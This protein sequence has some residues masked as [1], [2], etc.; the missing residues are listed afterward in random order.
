MAKQVPKFKHTSHVNETVTR[1]TIYTFC[2]SPCHTKHFTTTVAAFLWLVP[3]QTSWFTLG[4][5]LTYSSQSLCSQ[6]ALSCLFYN[7]TGPH[8]H[9]AAITSAII[10]HMVAKVL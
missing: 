4:N 2:P 1:L 8:T 5:G 9:S 3:Q 7:W 6:S 10:V